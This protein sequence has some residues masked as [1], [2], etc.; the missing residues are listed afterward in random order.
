MEPRTV[1]LLCRPIWHKFGIE[2]NKSFLAITLK[3]FCLSL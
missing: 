2:L 1:Y 3:R